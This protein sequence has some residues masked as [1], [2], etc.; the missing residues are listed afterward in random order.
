MPTEQRGLFL[1]VASRRTLPQHVV[2]QL[3]RLRTHGRQ[4]RELLL[5]DIIC[6]GAFVGVER[7]PIGDDHIVVV[8]RA[9]C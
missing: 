7:A 2:P 5:K 3:L 9:G 6:M 1:L 4:L 8:G